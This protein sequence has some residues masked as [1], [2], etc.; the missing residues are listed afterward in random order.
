MPARIHHVLLIA[1]DATRRHPLIRP[2]EARDCVVT[3]AAKG[4][5]GCEVAVRLSPDVVLLDLNVADLEGIEVCRRI[6]RD[7]AVPLLILS[8]DAAESEKIAALNSG[9]DDY[10]VKPFSPLEVVARVQALLRRAAAAGAPRGR[11][12]S[13]SFTLDF[14]QHRVVVDSRDVRLTPKELELLAQLARRP[15]CVVSP[16]SL[17]MAIWGPES[18]DHPEHLWVLVRQLRKKLEPDA[19][20]PQYLISDPGFGYRLAIS[21]A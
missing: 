6:R 9:A 15:N 11:L 4:Q 5:K 2:L 16:Q 17:L 8:S 18:V 21:P 1:D 3:C 20:R 13:G 10:V 7:S 19:A 12:T 14:D